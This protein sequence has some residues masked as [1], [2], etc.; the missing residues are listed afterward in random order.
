MFKM[1][2]GYEVL[3]FELNDKEIDSLIERLKELKKSEK[4][5]HYQL[6]KNKVV[7]IDD[8][9]VG[10]LLIHHEDELR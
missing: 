2:D 1:E 4:H 10:E 5:I 6:D 7:I 3:E 9:K 8:V